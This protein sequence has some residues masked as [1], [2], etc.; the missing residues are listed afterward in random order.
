MTSSAS[1]M[2]VGEAERKEEDEVN[3]KADIRTYVRCLRQPSDL[4]L[5]R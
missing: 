5:F 1:F 2:D 3:A 4:L